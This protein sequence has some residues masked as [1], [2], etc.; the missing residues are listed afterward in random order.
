MLILTMN[1]TVGRLPFLCLIPQSGGE[2]EPAD[3]GPLRAPAEDVNR[4]FTFNGESVKLK[5]YRI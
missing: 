3:Q 1:Q 4:R 5:R 2:R